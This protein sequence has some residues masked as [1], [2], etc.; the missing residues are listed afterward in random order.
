MLAPNYDDE[1]PEMTV[2]VAQ[3][4]FPKGN[5]VMKI[6]DELGSLFTDDEFAAL[7][8]TIGQPAA[9]PARLALVT[10]LQYMEN[11]TDRQA[12]DAVRSRI[13]WKYG[14]G[15]ELT[16]SGFDYSVLSEFRQRL[17][18]H[19]KETVLLDT[20]LERC[21]KN[22]LLKGKSKQ[23]TDS[24]HIL[25]AIRILNRVE[26]VGEAMR[27]VLD[28]IAQVAPEW[29]KIL[30]QPEWGKRYS[31]R[32]DTHHLSQT[33]R[34]ILAKEIGEDGHFLFKAIYRE[35]TPGE[36]KQLASV[37]VLRRIWI[38]QYYV[39]NNKI[40]WREKDQYGT[41]SSQTMISSPDDTEARYGSK[42][43]R[44]WT[45]YKVHLTETCDETGPRLIT[46]VETTVATTPDAGVLED[47]QDDL[48]TRDLTPE[49]HWVDGGYPNVDVLLSSQ[50]K[51]IDLIGPM[52]P[53]TSWQAKME[54]GY[55]QTKFEIDWNNMIATCPEGKTSIHWK[56]G[57]TATSRP[58]IHFA[59]SLPACTACPSRH[60][61]T[62]ANK[63]GRHV[64]VQPQKA[65]EI[66]KAA[67][68]RQTS[69]VFKELYKRRA[70]IEGTIA[71]AVR[72]KNM[73]Y[74]RYRGLYKTHLQ[75]LGTAA[76]IN[77]QRIASW[78]MG[79][80]PKGTRI[81]PFAALVIPF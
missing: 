60:L 9:S 56:E 36:V 13:D 21:Q 20:I 49:S 79:D 45:G 30:I 46:Q 34:K 53:D 1:I 81:S 52:R 22:G 74:A 24:S 14:L 43:S 48:I 72:G 37:E 2:E 12:A 75:H 51:G 47:I 63:I 29:L 62:K 71:Q 55:D 19:E 6:R 28:D 16:D 59:F 57:K 54:G 42:D 80:L 10:V 26:L 68:E 23:R 40:Y 27:R 58:N 35:D 11:L 38:Q 41:P 76:A 18:E 4:A 17:L 73:R 67:R 33:Q 66:Q 15:L 7:Y 8:P 70:G 64:T 78:L 5:V 44:T 69:E 65:Y 39:G 77:L 3:A 25:A 50:E 31:R 61:C 32:V